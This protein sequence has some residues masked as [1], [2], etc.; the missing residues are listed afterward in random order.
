MSKI[1]CKVADTGK[2]AFCTGV[3][4]RFWRWKTGQTVAYCW[5]CNGVFEE[6]LRSGSRGQ[7][8]CEEMDAVEYEAELLVKEIMER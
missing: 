7:N 8:L 2:N 3:A 5:A 1:A 4:S 6:R